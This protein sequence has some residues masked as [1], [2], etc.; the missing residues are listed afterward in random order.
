MNEGVLALFDLDGTITRR[1]TYLAYLLG[2][3]VRHPR[4]L[5][6][7][8]LLPFAVLRHLAGWRDNTWLKATFLRAVLGG[9]P[10]GRLDSW[11]E[12]FLDRTLSRGLRAGAL[13]TI[14][15]H[16]AAGHELILVTASLDFYADP[17]G[18]RL[19]FDPVLCTR[20]QYD[21]AGRVTGELDGG[22]CYGDD[23]L[24][25]VQD[26]VR[27]RAAGRQLAF[28]TDHHDDLPLLR[29]VQMPTVVNP[30]RRLRRQATELNI[31]IEDWG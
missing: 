31:T 22:N 3:L 13:E 11:T 10:R 6:R 9:I 17:L 18:R 30:T 24:K 20:A 8:A 14:E 12:L 28:Y 26:F 4:R 21:G 25:R 2:F 19:G 16:R 1:D 7:A 27:D 15:R 5:L 29:Y 23:K